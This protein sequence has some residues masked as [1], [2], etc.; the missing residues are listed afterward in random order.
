[1]E[2][3]S[4]TSKEKCCIWHSEEPIEGNERGVKG[5]K[6]CSYTGKKS[7]SSLQGETKSSVSATEVVDN[8]I[9]TFINCIYKCNELF[10]EVNSQEKYDAKLASYPDTLDVSWNRPEELSKSGDT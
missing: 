10:P 9:M 5:C 1:M 4:C 8:R 7:T 2:K 6:I 3:G